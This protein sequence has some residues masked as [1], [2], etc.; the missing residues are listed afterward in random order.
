MYSFLLSPYFLLR[1]PRADPLLAI[2]TVMKRIS[3]GDRVL[4][5]LFGLSLCSVFL[6]LISAAYYDASPFW[7]L[8][9]NLLLAWLPLLFAVWLV[10]YLRSSSWISW[11]G[12]GLTLLWLGFL[13]NS[14][15]LVTDF[16]HL[17]YA[18]PTQVLYYVMMLFAFG[19]T[20][21]LLGF[22]SLYLV[23]RELLKRLKTTNAHLWIGVV[24][25]LCSFAVYL[26]RYLRWS[27]WDIVLHP[28]GV[29]FDVSDR[30]I[31]PVAYGQT[32]QVTALF[33]ILLVGTYF[34]FWQLAAAGQEHKPH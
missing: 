21:M 16:I 32:F 31:N 15:Y 19:L 13:P 3:A 29:V 28:I 8:N 5:A 18:N 2:I 9:W 27:T 24:L 22:F 12:A 20:G 34:A 17:D 26:G 30:I 11:S 10:R 4:T 23:H 6:Y 33:F 14:F 25:L 7:F 1:P